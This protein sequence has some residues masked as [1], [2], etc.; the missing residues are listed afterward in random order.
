LSR[1]KQVGRGVRAACQL[2]DSPEG[3]RTPGTT[4]PSACTIRA[5]S[6]GIAFAPPHHHGHPR[7]DQQAHRSRNVI[8]R[9]FNGVTNWRGRATRD[10]KHATID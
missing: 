9:T 4:L 7:T 3:L 2:V 10:D 6:A 5:L 1:A 8:E